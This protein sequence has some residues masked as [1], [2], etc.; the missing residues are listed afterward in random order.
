M[1][2]KKKKTQKKKEL[3]HFEDNLAKLEQIIQQLEDGD[4]SLHETLELYESGVK[5]SRSCSKAL[6][7]A[8]QK[9]FILRNDIKE[10]DD[11]TP[12]KQQKGNEEGGLFDEFE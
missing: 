7:E 10:P 9:V 2:D 4:H 12:E 5:L 8:E 6:A 3:E 11:V 1:P